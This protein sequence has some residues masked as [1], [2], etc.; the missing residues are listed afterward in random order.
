MELEVIMA[1]NASTI[2]KE[3]RNFW[4]LNILIQ[5]VAPTA[6]RKVFNDKIPPKDLANILSRNVKIIQDLVNKKVINTHEQKLLVR[7]P[8]FKLPSMSS[9]SNKT[10]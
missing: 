5:Y 4:I 2:S 8:G 9:S 10:G 3:D 6:V 1:D 7:I